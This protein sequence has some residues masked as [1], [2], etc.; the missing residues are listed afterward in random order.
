[1]TLNE[2]NNQRLDEGKILDMI[3]KSASLISA[4]KKIDNPMVKVKKL[5][6]SLEGK[7]VEEIKVMASKVKV[8]ESQEEFVTEAIAYTAIADV[9][10]QF[11]AGFNLTSAAE[12]FELII[13]LIRGL[14]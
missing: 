8:N 13:T 10:T 11:I 6:A 7:S 2:L 3:K 14:V 5:L 1:M 12:I 9:I 4:L